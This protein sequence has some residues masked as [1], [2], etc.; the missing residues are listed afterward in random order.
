MPVKAGIDLRTA[1]RITDKKA[2]TSGVFSYD[3]DN[4]VVKTTIKSIDMTSRINF[5]NLSKTEKK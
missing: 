3:N 2:S 1:M 4:I 5:G